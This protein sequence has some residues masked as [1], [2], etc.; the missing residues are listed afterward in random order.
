MCAIE[1]YPGK[2]EELKEFVENELSEMLVFYD[3]DRQNNLF[4]ERGKNPKVLLN[5][6]LDSV[7]SEEMGKTG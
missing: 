7:G 5:A 3:D 4:G 2:E 6:H 1:S